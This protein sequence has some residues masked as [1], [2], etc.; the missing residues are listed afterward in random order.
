M[1]VKVDRIHEVVYRIAAPFGDGDT[2]YMYLI[3]GRRLALVDTGTARAPQAIIQPALRSLG[4][5]LS[6]LDLILN[7]HA[8]LDHIG[9]NLALRRVSKAAVYLHQADLPLAQ[10]V[11]A[12]VESL[13]AR[14][15]TLQMPKE[16]LQQPVRRLTAMATTVAGADVLLSGGD[17]VQL[18]SGIQLRV[19]HCPGH[20]PGSVSYYWEAEGVLLAG[21][22]VQGTHPFY[23]TASDYRRSLADLARLE[24]LSLLCLGHTHASG[25]AVNEP[26]LRDAEARQLLEDAIQSADGLH[27]V[28]AKVVKNRPRAST[29]ELTREAY[30]RVAE[31][32]YHIPAGMALGMG[33]HWAAAITL[34]AH[35]E[36]ALEGSYPL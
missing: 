2:V 25:E 36:A 17:V 26:T 8:H 27:E 14:L 6:Q 34:L 9:G 32:I 13:V 22:A 7:T 15:R 11:D 24:K 3:T 23:V 16:M 5:D 29:T 10:S 20:T 30:A 4:I 18:G 31:Q 35:V 19:I 28:V 33:M 12:Q 1:A 21:D